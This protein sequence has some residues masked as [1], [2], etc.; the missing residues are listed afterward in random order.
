MA[1]AKRKIK[2]NVALGDDQH[3]MALNITKQDWSRI[4][5][6]YQCT[7]TAQQKKAIFNVTWNFLSF[8]PGEA[9]AETVRTEANEV[10]RA[11]KACQTF[12]D[13]YMHN[14]NSNSQGSALISERFEV[15][16][17]HKL[18][19]SYLTSYID[20]C[21]WALAEIKDPKNHGWRKGDMWNLWVKELTAI[22]REGRLPHQVR[23]DDDKNR[24]GKSS[25]FVVFIRELQISIPLEFR[26]PIH[27]E[28][29]LATAIVRAR[30]VK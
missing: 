3:A 16:K 2:L 12:L 29:A 11:Q 24:A 26:R 13:L 17:K 18:F 19:H 25:P 14:I 9:G 10:G 27:S 22:A 20:A 15:H 21:D 8:V 7:L 6:A 23:Q 5:Q 1:V 30:R 28:S 4:E